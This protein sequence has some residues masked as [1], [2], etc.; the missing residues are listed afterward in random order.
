MRFHT[1]RELIV[2]YLQIHLDVTWPNS[3]VK[4]SLLEMLA[5]KYHG[6]PGGLLNRAEQKLW[7]QTVRYC[8]R[9][10]EANDEY[11]RRRHEERV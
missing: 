8:R 4:T 9:L 1:E 2:A 6:H 11:R 3:G 7:D 5:R 10:A